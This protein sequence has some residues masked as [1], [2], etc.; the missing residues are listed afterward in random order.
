MKKFLKINR[1]GLPLAARHAL[2]NEFPEISDVEGEEMLHALGAD[3]RPYR[4][5][6]GRKSYHAYR[7]HFDA[8]GADIEVWNGLVKKELAWRGSHFYHVTV[9]GIHLLEVLTLCRIYDARVNVADCKTAVL[10]Q[11]IEHDVFC[12]YGCWNPVSARQIAC[13]LAIPIDLARKTLRAL[14]DDGWVFKDHYGGIDDEGFPYCI[15]GWSCTKKTRRLDI[16]REMQKAE[17]VKI[18]KMMHVPAAAQF[19]GEDAG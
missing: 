3:N 4:E 13:E 2:K 7:N 10:K 9:R 17:Y 12:G 8:G 19:N 11:M 18:D 5:R 1:Q 6:L 14:A 15:H 16:H